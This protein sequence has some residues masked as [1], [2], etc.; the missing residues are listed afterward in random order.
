MTNYRKPSILQAGVFALLV[1]LS[2]CLLSAGGT[3]VANAD[4]SVA[5]LLCE[6]LCASEFGQLV[7]R[8][9][10]DSACIAANQHHLDQCIAQCHD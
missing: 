4:T 10:G 7:R 6:K 2:I 9:G 8:C 1:A 5:R 3:A